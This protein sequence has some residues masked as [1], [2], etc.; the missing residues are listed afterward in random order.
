MGIH[1][2]WS[3]EMWALTPGCLGAHL[4]PANLG[5]L[6][7]LSVP[8]F[9]CWKVGMP[10]LRGLFWGSEVGVPVHV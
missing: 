1:V 2:A 7:G 3:L 10:L 8:Q 4:G 6:L 9:L 5:R